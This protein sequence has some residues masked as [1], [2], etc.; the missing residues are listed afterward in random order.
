[1]KYQYISKKACPPQEKTWLC[2]DCRETN[3]EQILTG[4]WRLVGVSTDSGLRCA[5]CHTAEHN[6]SRPA[7][8]AVIRSFLLAL[9]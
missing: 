1:M 5:G 8:F 6:V 7:G 3:I 9:N 4:S 2:A